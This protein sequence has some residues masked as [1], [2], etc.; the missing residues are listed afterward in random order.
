MGGEVPEVAGRLAWGLWDVA[1][2]G[3]GIFGVALSRAW[4]CPA[5]GWREQ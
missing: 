4:S 5:G 3:G 2:Q 1:E